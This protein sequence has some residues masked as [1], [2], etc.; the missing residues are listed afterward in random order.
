MLVF[1][2]G[3]GSLLIIIVNK[4]SV[5]MCHLAFIKM[6]LLLPFLP[7]LWSKCLWYYVIFCF[8]RCLFLD[9][10]YYWLW[11]GVVCLLLFLFVFIYFIFFGKY[12][13]GGGGSF[14]T[15]LWLNAELYNWRVYRRHNSQDNCFMVCVF[16]GS[17]ICLCLCW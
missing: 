6:N 3:S 13:P 14:L 1:W 2:L 8:I 11:F 12:P 7:F 15:R 16:V 10:F 9:E 4:D 17:L 5:V